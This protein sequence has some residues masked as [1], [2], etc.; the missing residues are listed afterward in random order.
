[1]ID[2]ALAAELHPLFLVEEEY[3]IAMLDAETAYVTRL[4]GRITDP[5]AGW[6]PLWAQFHSQAATDGRAP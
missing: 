5:A 2:Q 6:G 3:R 4:I 1:V